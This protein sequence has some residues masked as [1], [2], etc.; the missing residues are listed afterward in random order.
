[1]T[2]LTEKQQ[3]LPGELLND[4]KGHTKD[5]LGQHGLIKQIIRRALES[6]LEG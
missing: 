4:F 6:A 3:T 1:M 5:L 2:E